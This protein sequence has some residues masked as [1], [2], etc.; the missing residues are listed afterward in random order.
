M[1]RYT[2]KMT[3]FSIRTPTKIENGILHLP[4]GGTSEN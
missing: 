1:T 3:T 4:R 2:M